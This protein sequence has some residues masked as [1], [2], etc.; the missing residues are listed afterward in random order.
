[1]KHM[2]DIQK[3]SHLDLQGV[4]K[5]FFLVMF[6]YNNKEGNYIHVYSTGKSIYNVMTITWDFWHKTKC[7]SPA[8]CKRKASGACLLLA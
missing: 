1:M 5:C 4:V 6:T 8:A 3:R 7:F 2:C